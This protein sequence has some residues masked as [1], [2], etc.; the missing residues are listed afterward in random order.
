[1]LPGEDLAAFTRI[2]RCD[3]RPDHSNADT[4]RGRDEMSPPT[5]EPGVIGLRVSEPTLIPTLV[6][7]DPGTTPRT[8]I[9]HRYAPDG[10]S[11]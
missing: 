1:M 5:T 3:G 8:P 11:S 10:A 6:A 9:R 4:T 2:G 7:R